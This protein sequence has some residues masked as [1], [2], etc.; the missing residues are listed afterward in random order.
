M[1]ELT[2]GMPTYSKERY[3]KG[4]E[5]KYRIVTVDQ[6]FFTEEYSKWQDLQDCHEHIRDQDSK[7][8]WIVYVVE[9]ENNNMVW[10]A[11]S[12]SKRNKYGYAIDPERSALEWDNRDE[13][14]ERILENRNQNLGYWKD[15]LEKTQ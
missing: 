4:P 15:L 7:K 9:D 8:W 2:F 6:R 10:K 13:Q 12:D 3:E 1:A 11:G 14:R 5:G